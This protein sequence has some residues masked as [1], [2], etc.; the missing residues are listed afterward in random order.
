[1]YKIAYEVVCRA[2]TGLHSGKA[3]SLTFHKVWQTV[4]SLLGVE[5]FPSTVNW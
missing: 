4:T 2:R 1:M 5:M 3:C